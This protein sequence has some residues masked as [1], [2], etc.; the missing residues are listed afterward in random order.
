MNSNED[1]QIDDTFHVE[2]VTIPPNPRGRGNRHKLKPGHQKSSV[3]RKT[4]HSVV[5]IQNDD[6]LC[7]ARAIV[8][9][10]AKADNHPQYNS[11]KRSTGRMQTTLAYR[12]HQ[13]AGSPATP[14]GWESLL[15]YQAVLPEYRLPVC[16][17]DYEYKVEV[18]PNTRMKINPS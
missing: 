7:A 10:K 5:T 11:I 1:F 18:C 14:I 9:A 12:L 13:A 16:Y 2:I 17:E 3:F 8:V 15:Q 4:K 6:D